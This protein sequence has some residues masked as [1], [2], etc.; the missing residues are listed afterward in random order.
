MAPWNLL[1]EDAEYHQAALSL[2]P[3]GRYN[4]NLDNAY[5]EEQAHHGIVESS[6]PANG[7][8]IRPPITIAMI[9]PQRMVSHTG[10]PASL[11][12]TAEV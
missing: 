1:A 3:F 7:Y 8:A 4:N 6:Q 2:C 10:Q 11:A 9:P 5:A 12:I